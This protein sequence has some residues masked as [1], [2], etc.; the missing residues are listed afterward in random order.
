MGQMVLAMTGTVGLD[1]CL[2]EIV[3][4]YADLSRP[5]P[6]SPWF[7]V[8]GMKVQ[9]RSPSIVWGQIPVALSLEHPQCR[10]IRIGHGESS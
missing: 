3:E 5:P 8:G 4:S 2:G 6:P 1:V 10:R 7:V 9:P